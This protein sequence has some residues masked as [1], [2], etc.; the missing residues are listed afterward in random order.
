[1]N[2]TGLAPFG[3]TPSFVVTAVQV[4]MIQEVN[5]FTEAVFIETISDEPNLIVA[6]PELQ[7]NSQP[8]LQPTSQ[9]DKVGIISNWTLQS[10]LNEIDGIYRLCD[11]ISNKTQLILQFFQI[12]DY[13]VAKKITWHIEWNSSFS[14]PIDELPSRYQLNKTR[15]TRDTNFRIIRRVRKASYFTRVKQLLKWLFQNKKFDG[16]KPHQICCSNNSVLA[17]N[18]LWNMRLHIFQRL[19]DSV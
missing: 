16:V 13:D 5:C 7:M 8:N 14:M 3:I 9:Q 15:N 2:L 6:E 18:C 11:S 17:Q 10:L 12:D 1:M 4:P 19:V